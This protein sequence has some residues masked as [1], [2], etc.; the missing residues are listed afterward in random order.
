MITLNSDFFNR[1][2]LIVAKELLGKVLVR[3]IDGQILSGR[4][5]ET[6]AY[7]A[8]NDEAAHGYRGKTKRNSS[9]FMTA[10]H[11][12]VHRIHMQHCLDIVTEDVDVP[13]SV[14][15]RAIE[16]LT[17]IEIMQK[18]RGRNELL[19]LT[20]G[21]GKLAEALAIDKTQDAID[22]TDEQSILYIVDDGFSVDRG[23]IVVTKRVGISKAMEREYRFYIHGNRFVSRK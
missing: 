21:P 5:V 1:S 20:S 3:K 11:V 22:V 4:I 10:G 17:G 8:V 15:I 7:I 16:P 18:L 2:P 9:L 13:S 19:A 12:Y 23:D 6:E 14:L